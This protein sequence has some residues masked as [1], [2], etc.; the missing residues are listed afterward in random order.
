MSEKDPGW[1][2]VLTNPSMPNLVKIGRT[3]RDPETRI[4]ELSTPTGVPTP[5]RLV[6]KALVSDCSS[7][8]ELVHSILSQRGYRISNKREFFN[9][10]LHVAIEIVVQVQ[11]QFSI[12]S[13][14][15]EGNYS[16]KPRLI[17]TESSPWNDGNTTWGDFLKTANAFRWG[18]DG[19]FQDIGKAIEN[20]VIA[21]KLGSSTAYFRLGE[22]YMREALE[23]S[24]L[25]TLRHINETQIKK[26]YEKALI[27]FKHGAELGDANCYYFMA[28]CYKQ[29]SEW[30]YAEELR[31]PYLDNYFKC[32]DRIFECGR[33]LKERVDDSIRLMLEYCSDVL[34]YNVNPKHLSL[35]K[36]KK[37]EIDN[38]LEGTLGIDE[39]LRTAFNLICG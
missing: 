5:F 10:P 34:K 24:S 30:V 28:L 12:A 22:I 20:Y 33:F 35:I 32:W 18:W 8:E 1:I 2:Y 6:Y 31:Q 16:E 39:E 29:M 25:I 11:N 21:G 14:Q 23:H 17:N 7:A 3:E 26:I 4:S 15:G 37:N 19:Q 13:S 9:A 36:S 27:S 38:Y